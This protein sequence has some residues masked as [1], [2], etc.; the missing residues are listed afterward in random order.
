[1]INDVAIN[2]TNNPNLIL[3]QQPTTPHVTVLHFIL[4]YAQSIL[5]QYTFGFII[6]LLYVD[7]T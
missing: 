3:N 6:L 2:L 5:I 7:N 4:T 1:M